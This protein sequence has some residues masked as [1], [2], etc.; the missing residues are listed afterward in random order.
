MRPRR[1]SAAR[2]AFVYGAV[3]ALAV[4]VTGCTFTP[5]PRASAPVPP[6][7]INSA[8]LDQYRDAVARRIVERSPS[9]VLHGTPQAMLRSLVVVSFTVDGNGHVLRSVGVSH[10]RRRRSREHRARQ[11]AARVAVAAAAGQTA[12]RPRPAR[13]LRRL[14]FQRQRQVPVARIRVTAGANHR[15]THRRRQSGLPGSRRRSL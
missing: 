8:T 9:Y 14:A 1:M 15:L 7:A 11:S 12:E 6:A 2:P 5:P 13:T 3:L 10:E 4:T